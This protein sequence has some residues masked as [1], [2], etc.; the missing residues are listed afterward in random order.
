[1]PRKD[2]RMDQQLSALLTAWWTTGDPDRARV[3]A[4]GSHHCPSAAGRGLL[5]R[6]QIADDKPFILP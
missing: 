6:P 2:I 1:M 3:L 4:D 5:K